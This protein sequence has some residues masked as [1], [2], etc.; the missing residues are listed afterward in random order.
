MVASRADL[1][2]NETRFA[3][4]DD[5][6]ALIMPGMPRSERFTNLVFDALEF[7]TAYREFAKMAASPTAPPQARY[8]F[9]ALILGSAL[10]K[11]LGDLMPGDDRSLSATTLVGDLINPA[12]APAAILGSSLFGREALGDFAATGSAGLSAV[13]SAIDRTPSLGLAGADFMEFRLTLDKLEKQIERMREADTGEKNT[14]ASD[15]QGGSAVEP[16]DRPNKPA[17]PDGPEMEAL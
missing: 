5:R 3:H 6:G 12:G 10:V 8:A 2:N 15:R 1:G 9:V 7:G 4:F 13:R 11:L 17:G 14:S 16:S